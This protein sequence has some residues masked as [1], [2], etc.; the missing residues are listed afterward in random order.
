MTDAC[1][2]PY[3]IHTSS[4]RTTL[5]LAGV[6]STMGGLWVLSF[7]DLAWR[8]LIG[9]GLLLLGL[10]LIVVRGGLEA[11]RNSTARRR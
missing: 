2:V 8:G 1:Y 10:T 6:V 7:T 5:L 9:W 11:R 4:P 3:M